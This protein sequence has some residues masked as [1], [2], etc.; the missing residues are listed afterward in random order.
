MVLSGIYT[1]LESIL[2]NKGIVEV[3]DFIVDSAVALLRG[4][5]PIKNLITIRS[6]AANYKNENYF[7][8]VFAKNLKAA[9]KIVNPGDRL[10]YIVVKS[11][12]TE[13]GHKM[14][15]PEIY[16]EQ[17]GTPKEEQIDY[18]YYL[19]HVLKGPMD[20]LFSIGF[21][22]V[23]KKLPTVGYTPE[24][25]RCTFKPLSEPINM[26]VYALEDGIDI[27]DAKAMVKGHV[28]LKQ[29]KLKLKT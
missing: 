28:T 19:D 23:L 22:N 25:K 4:D 6:V 12:R 1:V 11:D 17:I 18:L 27:A 20:L 15:D 13:V 26:L 14:R 5:I 16:F 3:F 2:H 24:N 10:D 21:Q 8:N 9:G 29:K 7:M